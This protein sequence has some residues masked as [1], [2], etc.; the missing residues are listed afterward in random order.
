MRLGYSVFIWYNYDLSGYSST[1]VYA[2]IMS[3]AWHTAKAIVE[4]NGTYIEL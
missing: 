1:T 3:Q 2:E 4:P